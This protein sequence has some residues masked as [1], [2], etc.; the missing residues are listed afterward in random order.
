M[1]LTYL[2][3]LLMLLK[4]YLKRLL[5]HSYIR[6]Y[7][8]GEGIISNK[9][10]TGSGRT[11]VAQ[12]DKLKMRKQ[13]LINHSKKTYKYL[14]R[15]ML[16]KNV[17]RQAFYKMRKGKRKR[18]TVQKIEADFENYVNK[19]QIILFNTIPGAPNPE[20]GFHPPKHKPVIIR[21]Y[22]KQREIYVPSIMEQWVHHVIMQVLSPIFMNRFH[23]DS[24]G[25]VPR[26]GLHRGKK[27]YL[28]YRHSY[29]YGF[30]FDIRHFYA[31][32]RLD[33]L[34]N[35]LRKFIKDEWMIHLIKICFTHHQKGLPL[36]FYLSQW[37]ANV[38][39]TDLDNLLDNCGIKHIRYVDDVMMFSNSKSQ[40]KK[41][42]A[43]VKQHL[44]K[45]RLKVKKNY[46]LIQIQKEPVSFLGF[47]FMKNITR[48]RKPIVQ[49]I[50]RTIKAIK[51]ANKQHR[52]VWIKV[53]RR[54]MSYMGWIKNSNAYTLFKTYM[55]P[56]I[57]MKKIRKHI[58]MVDNPNKYK[59][60][61]QSAKK[62]LLYNADWS[63]EQNFL[64]QYIYGKER[65]LNEL[66]RKGQRQVWSPT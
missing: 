23:H 56:N 54:L 47:V 4:D 12:E 53:E 7:W 62:V 6:H 17:I 41:T 65:L 10:A 9:C 27:A 33:V 42:F 40:L 28:K 43:L 60:R 20:L 11:S 48:L 19:M 2:K 25:S 3:S 32:V 15:K 64:Y 51:K 52:K 13:K 16:D 5:K 55:K 36:G 30:K 66:C 37:M 26:G 45:L 24:Y 34:I 35:C 8:F 14:Y 18:A 39:L 44:G 22:S 46:S 58:S 59:K 1:P 57:N 21:E 61:K 29:K 63:K 38:V 49:H 50:F 31:N